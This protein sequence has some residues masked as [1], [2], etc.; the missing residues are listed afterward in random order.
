MQSTPKQNFGIFNSLGSVDI[1]SALLPFGLMAMAAFFVPVIGALQSARTERSLPIISKLIPGL[2]EFEEKIDKIAEGQDGGD[3]NWISKIYNQFS[4]F[5]EV[6]DTLTDADMDGLEPPLLDETWGLGVRNAS[7][8]NITAN[9]TIEEPVKLSKEESSRKKRSI[10]DDEDVAENKEEE[11]EELVDTEEKCRVDMWRCLSKVIEGGLHY[12]DDPDGL[13]GLAKKT[14]FKI[15]FHGGFS[16]VWSGVMTIPEARH[17]KQ[18][19]NDH[20]ECVS[21]EILRREAQE[22]LDPSDP[23]YDMY[24]KKPTKVVKDKHVSEK[25]EKKPKRERLIINPEFVES[26]D[27][28]DGSVQYDEDYTIDENE[29]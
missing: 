26:L 29:V 27:Q 28:G 14:M 9:T 3:D 1:N 10:D 7:V 16:N 20:S 13:M 19:M 22:T 11:E 2:E 8:K 24:K 12:I 15:A 23:A 17:I 18:C 6:D 21:Y 5:N 4:F 25:E